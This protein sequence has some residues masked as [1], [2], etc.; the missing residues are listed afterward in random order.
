MGLYG[1]LVVPLRVQNCQ[2]PLIFRAERSY[3]SELKSGLPL[4]SVSP[5]PPPPA[6]RDN[7]CLVNWK[8]CARFRGR[9]Q[10][11]MAVSPEVSDVYLDFFEN[12]S[13]IV[14]QR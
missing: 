4:K 8:I 5:H 11:S 14:F 2:P 3:I 13:E 10:E 12:K 9:K 1:A 6:G 7:K